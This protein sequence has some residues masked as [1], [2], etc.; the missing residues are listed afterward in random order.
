MPLWELGQRC[1]SQQLP[2]RIHI[3]YISHC[4]FLHIILAVHVI[5]KCLASRLA[6]QTKC[7]LHEMLSIS[8]MEFSWGKWD[9][10]IAIAV[11]PNLKTMKYSQILTLGHIERVYFSASFDPKNTIL[12]REMCNSLRKVLGWF[13]IFRLHEF[14][15]FQTWNH[16]VNLKNILK[17]CG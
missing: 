3:S 4:E 13:N 11:E 15:E 2:H 8:V 6:Y 12:Y 10:L 5:H 1:C 7:M 16:A 17:H 9:T 14:G